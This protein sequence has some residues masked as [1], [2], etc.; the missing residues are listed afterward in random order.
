MKRNLTVETPGEIAG[1][2]PPAPESPQPDSVLTG[3][4]STGAAPAAVA[5]PSPDLAPEVPAVVQ[6]DT[7]DPEAQARAAKEAQLVQQLE[8]TKG[9]VGSSQALDWSHLTQPAA[10]ELKT[11][12]ADANLPNDSDFDPFKIPFGGKVL[13][14]QGWLLSTQP[15]PRTQGR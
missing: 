3:S 6:P 4:G 12:N 8:Q 9:L 14:R 15:D 13:T 10:I 7:A 2:M 5:A 11:K 1:A